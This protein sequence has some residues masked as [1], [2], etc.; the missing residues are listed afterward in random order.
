MRPAIKHA[1]AYLPLCFLFLYLV[2][3]TRN[4][5]WDGVLFSLNIEAVHRGVLPALVLFHP[6]HLLYSALGYALYSAALAC[7]IDIRA[8]SVLAAFNAFIGACAA[9]VLFALSKR[10]TGSSTIAL[11]SA[12]LFAAGAMWW[13]YSTDADSYIPCLLLLLLA[14]YFLFRQPGNLVA[15]A[16]CHTGAMLLHELAIFFYVPVLLAIALEVPPA[17]RRISRSI[18]YAVSSGLCVTVAYLLCYQSAD[19]RAYPSLA[20]W[21]TSYDVNSRFT[22]S[23]REI[24]GS[25]ISGYWKLFVG[26]KLSLL[27]DYLSPLTVLALCVCVAALVCAMYWWRHREQIARADAN[28]QA[29]FVLWA[30][31]LVYAVFLASWDPGST[32]HKLFLWPSIVLLIGVYANAKRTWIFLALAIAAWNFAAFIY[33]HAQASADPI[34]TLA[35]TIDRQLPKNAVVYYQAFDTDDWYLAYFAPGR[36]WLPLSH[37]LPRV[38]SSS[39]PV[40]FETTALEALKLHLNSNYKWDLVDQH[41]NIRL[42]CTP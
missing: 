27:R 9:Y 38:A 19:H 8:I 39:V 5:Y 25:Y 16:A 4:Y 23:L 31:F 1:A 35:Q 10:L 7:G 32:F 21:I 22:H 24:A 37:E 3:P 18:F 11:F 29:K 33:P 6:N 42:E 14:A 36:E 12:L 15:V 41:H 13:K 20:R 28:R 34:L 40:C 17:A 2:F 26:G 30:W